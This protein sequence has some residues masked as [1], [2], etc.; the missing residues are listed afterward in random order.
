MQYIHFNTYIPKINNNYIELVQNLPNEKTMN[1]LIISQRIHDNFDD[2]E[3]EKL[4]TNNMTYPSMIIPSDNIPVASL[5]DEF[6]YTFRALNFA[7][8]D[9]FNNIIDPETKIYNDEFNI[10]SSA[11]ILKPIN[12]RLN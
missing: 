1:N 12:K 4:I 2:N 7:N 6:G 3:I 8:I 10:V 5:F 11:F 9:D